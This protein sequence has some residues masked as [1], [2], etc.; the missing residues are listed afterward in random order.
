MTKAHLATLVGALALAGACGGGGGGKPADAGTDV[1]S[2]AAVAINVAV[3]GTAS[4]HP[5]TLML[6]PTADFTNLQVSIVDPMEDILMHPPQ[7]GATMVLNTSPANCGVIVPDAGGASDGGVD[8]AADAATGS[9]ASVAVDAAED[10]PLLGDGSAGAGDG[11]LSPPAS[12]GSGC[13]W[14]FASVD[15]S[16]IQLGLVGKLEDL[17]AAG[18]K[19]WVKTGTGAGTA[20]FIT[21]E[22]ADKAPI[23]GVPLFAVSRNTEAMLA[24]FASTVLSTTLTGDDLEARGYLI[25]HAVGKKS[26]GAPPIAGATVTVP[27]TVASQLDIIY[28][29]ATFTGVGTSTSANGL[30]L[31]VPKAVATPTAIVAAWQMTAPG[32]G[33]TWQLYTAGTEPG[34][35]FVLI[36]LADEA[37]ASNGGG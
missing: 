8:A 16:K 3:S 13:A 24:A 32:S 9:D 27:A 29:N 28:P 19:V 6:D 1:N 17:R 30:F 37:D 34:A 26:A 4:P 25:G 35:A 14:Q 10:A 20:A 15:I 7:A 36:F 11:A 22:K 5:L 21:M 31:A 33:E 2:D 12:A 23:T 18:S